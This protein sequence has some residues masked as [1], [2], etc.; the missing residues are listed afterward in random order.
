[1]LDCEWR[2]KLLNMEEWKNGRME[3]WNDGILGDCLLKWDDT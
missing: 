2:F 1:M 3:Y